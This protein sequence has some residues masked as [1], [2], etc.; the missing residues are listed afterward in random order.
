M[1]TRPRASARLASIG[2]SGHAHFQGDG[3]GQPLGHADQ[4]AAA[5]DQAALGFGD[6]EDGVLDR[7]HEV[8]GQ[9]DL[10]TTGQGRPIDGGD[11]R[12]GEDTGGDAGEA[13]LAV[14]DAATLAGGERL[15]VHAGAEGLVAGPGDDDHPAVI[16]GLEVIHDLGHALADRPVDGVALIGAVD[17]HDFDVPVTLSQYFVGHG[18]SLH[19][20]PLI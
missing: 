20:R 2:I 15:E 14:D 19:N 8:A 10:E 16:I 3:H 4:P 7:H 1:L 18:G 9:H 17:G 12:L 11:D 13:T 6:T 5:G